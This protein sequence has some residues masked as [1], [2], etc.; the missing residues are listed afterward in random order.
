M[1]F[2]V[3]EDQA[4]SEKLQV[5][6]PLTSATNLPAY[7]A[8]LGIPDYVSVDNFQVEKA[9]VILWACRHAK[10]F[11]PDETVSSID[12]ALFGGC[13]FKF[14]CPSTNSKGPLHRFVGDIDIVTTREHGKALVRLLCALSEKLG[15]KYYVTTTK[16]DKRFNALRGGTR[17]RVRVIKEIDK[18]GTPTLGVMDIFC[19]KLTFCHEILVA[20]EVKNAVEQAYTI[21]FEN[22]VLTKTQFIKKVPRDQVAGSE[23]YRLLGELDKKNVIL[24]MEMKDMRDICAMLLDHEVGEGQSTLSLKAFSEKLRKDWRLAKTVTLNLR[25]LRDNPDAMN[26]LGIETDQATLIRSRLDKLLQTFGDFKPKLGL[27]LNKEWWEE[28]EDQTESMNA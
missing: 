9:V 17:F 10:E 20:H 18:E 8:E 6:I 11:L 24:G 25:N 4:Q 7:K 1:K 14:A 23:R 5:D 16:Y 19:D 26:S 15:S 3:Y 28:V 21:G 13:G 2:T 12:A 22:L 27:S